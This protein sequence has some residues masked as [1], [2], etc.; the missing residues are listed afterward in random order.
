VVLVRPG[1]GAGDAVAA[2]WFGAANGDDV[3]PV[4]A[5]LECTNDLRSDAHNVPLAKLED[6]VIQQYATRSPDH[7]VGLF[8]LAVTMRK[9][10]AQ[11]G[12]E[13]D[14]ADAEITRVEVL[15]AK[16]KLDPGRSVARGVL[17]VQQIHGGEAGHTLSFFTG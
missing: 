7:N 14:M 8:L 15:P 3:E 2:L 6:L 4:W 11:V 1:G 16:A 17:D 5:R 9:G 12:L 13:A 10:A